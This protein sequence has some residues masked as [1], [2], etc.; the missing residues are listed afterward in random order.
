MTDW[1]FDNNRRAQAGIH[2][3]PLGGGAGIPRCVACDQ[4]WPCESAPFRHITPV[5]HTPAAVSYTVHTLTK[6][7]AGRWWETFSD[8]PGCTYV[9]LD[10]APDETD[11]TGRAVRTVE[12][13]C[14]VNVDYDA[15]GKAIGIEFT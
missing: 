4:P 10:G 2:S 11:D 5:R 12:L 13:G 1:S 14:G 9:Y 15:D 8:S 3:A 7:A 6:D